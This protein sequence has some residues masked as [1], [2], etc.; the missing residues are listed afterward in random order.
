MRPALSMLVLVACALVAAPAFCQDGDGPFPKSIKLLISSKEGGGYTLYGRLMEKHM[1]RFLPGSPNI[2]LQS[3]FGAGGV[4]L[5]NYMSNVAPRDGSALGLV[6]ATTVLAPILAGNDARFDGRKLSWI[7]SLNM[8]GGFCLSWHDSPVTSWQD[9]LDREFLVGATGANSRG[10]TWPAMLNKLFGTKMKVISGYAGGNEVLIAMERGEIHGRCGTL[11]A[12][13]RVTR[14]DWL[15]EKKLAAPITIARERQPDFPD[16]PSI[17]EF[18]SGKDERTRNVLEL[19]FKILEIDRPF[20]APPELPGGRLATLRTA[21]ERMMK[22][23][24]FSQEGKKLNLELV[25]GSGDHVAQAV[26]WIYTMPQDVIMD[27]G[28]DD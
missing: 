19:I 5:A 23:P 28:G 8:T 2:T 9:M 4:R 18:A 21:F 3:M 26:D 27:A 10:A 20:M 15:V 7:G 13:V 22:D 6:N 14:P 16:S 25:F 17:A 24:A 12:G 1:P 11:L